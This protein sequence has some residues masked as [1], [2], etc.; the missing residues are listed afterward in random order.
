MKTATIAAIRFGYGLGPEGQ[1]DSPDAVLKSLKLP[2]KV[3]QAYPMLDLAAAQKM[4]TEVH[5]LARKVKGGGKAAAERR[6]AKQKEINLETLGALRVSL[7][8]IAETSS[9]F[10]ERLTTFWSD[11][12]TAPVRGVSLTPF[13]IAK[14]DGA[15]RPNLTGRFADLLSAAVLHPAMLLYLDQTSSVGPN[16]PAGKKRNLGLN[17]NLAREVLELH[18]MGVGGS[19]TQDDV[20]QFAELLTGLDF[21]AARG[22]A[23]LPPKAEPG[24]ETILGQSYGGEQPAR[25]DD[26]LAFLDDLSVHP[27]TAAH[28]SRKLAVHFV[29]D[30]P[31]QALV[32]QMSATWTK[33]GGDLFAVYDAMLRHPDAWTP[34]FAKAKQ[35]FDFVASGIVALG[36]GGDEIMAMD[37]KKFRRAMFRTLNVMGQ[38]F[39]L[40]GGP[41]GWPEEAEAWITPLGVSQR[42]LWGLQVPSMLRKELPDPRSFVTRVLDDAASPRLVWAVGASETVPQGVGLVFASPE[43]NRR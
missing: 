25:L 34:V 5:A 41:N 21:R 32:D 39:M 20:R 10:R 12:F 9:P 14:I 40:P 11:H 33:T 18:T 3:A 23:F 13:A 28:V 35:P 29:S 38:R 16:S 36:I 43:F 1:P 15:L 42:I 4:V 19:F 2:D 26:I 7:A 27:D 30:D 37:D 22:F 24:A 6:T 8:R 31:P 17:E